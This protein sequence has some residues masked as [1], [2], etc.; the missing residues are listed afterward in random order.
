M[1]TSIMVTSTA[2][3]DQTSTSTADAGQTSTSTPYADQPSG[4]KPNI[5]QRMPRELR[6]S[7]YAYLT[8]TEATVLSGVNQFFHG[9]IDP[10]SWPTA[11]KEESILDAQLWARYNLM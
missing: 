2:D 1:A 5:I 11:E 4:P 8:Y 9:E 3:G 6:S 7:V 10:Q